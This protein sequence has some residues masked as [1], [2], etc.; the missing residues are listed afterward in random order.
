MFGGVAMVSRRRCKQT[1]ENGWS[2]GPSR[3]AGGGATRRRRR[4]VI[5]RAIACATRSMLPLLIAATQ[6]RPESRP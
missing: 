1:L 2:R 4:Y 5:T 6:M 3:A